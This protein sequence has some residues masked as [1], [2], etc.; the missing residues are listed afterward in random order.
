ML[1]LLLLFRINCNGLKTGPDRLVRRSAMVLVRSGQLDWNDFEP[2]S[3]RLNWRSNWWTNRFNYY[4]YFY[5]A[6]KR[7]RF[8]G[9]TSCLSLE[10]GNPCRLNPPL[11]AIVGVPLRLPPTCLSTCPWRAAPRDTQM[12]STGNR[13]RPATYGVGSWRSSS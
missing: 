6:S 11:V 2:G 5:I 13:Y 1:L 10:T 12:A 8:G 7:H 4:Y 3:D 9:Y